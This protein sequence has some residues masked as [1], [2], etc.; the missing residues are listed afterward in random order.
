[1]ADTTTLVCLAM[2]ANTRQE[3]LYLKIY[4]TVMVHFTW[5]MF[6]N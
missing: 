2:V 6:L 1:M 4:K 3:R 5:I